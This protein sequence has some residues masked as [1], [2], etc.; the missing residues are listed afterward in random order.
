[1]ASYEAKVHWMEV[2]REKADNENLIFFNKENESVWVIWKCFKF[3]TK[4]AF[5]ATHPVLGDSRIHLKITL[6]IFVQCL[7]TL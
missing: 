6:L 4:C 7:E 5:V 2:K 3:L 1:M